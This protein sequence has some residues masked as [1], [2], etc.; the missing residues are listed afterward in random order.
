MFSLCCEYALFLPFFANFS[1]YFRNP[2]TLILPPSVNRQC[3]DDDGLGDAIVIDCSSGGAMIFGGVGAMMMMLTTNDAAASASIASFATAWSTTP[4]S[5]TRPPTTATTTTIGG[6]GDA[7]VT[8]EEY[9]YLAS[10]TD[11]G[12]LCVGGR[13]I[14]VDERGCGRGYDADAVAAASPARASYRHSSASASLRCCRGRGGR[15]RDRLRGARADPR[16]NVVR[17]GTRRGRE[18][19]KGGTPLSPI[20]RTGAR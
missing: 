9:N 11:D 18:G 15:I 19:R 8:E 20:A 7:I 10:M 4:P 1:P 5:T 3:G 13:L 12:L 14:D 6:G 16:G 17:D 2:P